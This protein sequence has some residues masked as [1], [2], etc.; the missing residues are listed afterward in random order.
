[1]LVPELL[2]FG[3]RGGYSLLCSNVPVEA[4]F[5]SALDFA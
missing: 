5:D 2:D 3:I 4:F 1:M